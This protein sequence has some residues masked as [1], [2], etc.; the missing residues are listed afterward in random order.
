MYAIVGSTL[1][2]GGGA[3][4]YLQGYSL[5]QMPLQHF[6]YEYKY[7]WSIVGRDALLPEMIYLTRNSSALRSLE[8]NVQP[9]CHQFSSVNVRKQMHNQF[10]L[11]LY[12]AFCSSQQC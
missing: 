11:A 4:N 6:S 5:N 10:M 12:L 9:R 8:P 2:G 1:P 7:C 3:N